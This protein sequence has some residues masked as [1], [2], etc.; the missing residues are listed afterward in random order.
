MRWISRLIHVSLMGLGAFGAGCA[1]YAPADGTRAFLPAATTADSDFWPTRSTDRLQQIIDMG[2]DVLSVRVK[3]DT[4]VNGEI[5]KSPRRLPGFETRYSGVYG[6]GII[7]FYRPAD[8][9]P[10]AVSAGMCFFSGIESDSVE[11]RRRWS[12]ARRARSDNGS[13]PWIVN[14]RGTWMRLDDPTNGERPRGLI[15]HLTSFGGYRYELPVIEELRSR[16]WAVLW[17]DS[18]TVRPETTVIR[19]D[20]GNPEPAAETIAQNVSD[21]VS[22]IAYAVEAGL[23]FIGRERPDIPLSPLVLCAY[24]AGALSAPTVAAL[25]PNRIDAAVLVGGGANLLDISQRSALTD[26]GLKLQWKS[27]PSSQD[28]DH[29]ESLYLDKCRLDPY[30]TAQALRDKPVLMLHAVLDQIVPASDG[31]LLYKRLGCPERVNFLLGH[32]LLFFRLPA[33]KIMIADWIED[34]ITQ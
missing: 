23:D 12:V 22:E 9:E 6:R 34:R 20:P 30:W 16:G 18:S 1:W 11:A 25:I 10:S 27:R 19:V 31:D 28:R 2:P 5:I 26:G 3:Y 32:E 7:R 21:R 24:S 33:H 8:G 13:E 4:L 29:L 17:V 15:I 14:L